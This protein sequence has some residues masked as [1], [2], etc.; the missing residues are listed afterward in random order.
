MFHAPTTP[1][2]I[3][4]RLKWIF[5]PRFDVNDIVHYNTV[6]GELF[7]LA[8]GPDPKEMHLFW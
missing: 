7:F 1:N 3:E 8:T 6:T 5:T 4:R 2:K